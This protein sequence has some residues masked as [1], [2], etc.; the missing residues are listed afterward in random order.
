MRKTI[1]VLNTVPITSLLLCKTGY[2]WQIILIFIL[3]SLNL[4]TI[5]PWCAYTMSNIPYVLLGVWVWYLY[6]TSGRVM[7]YADK[8][9]T[10]I[11]SLFPYFHKT[12]C[13]KCYQMM[14]IKYKTLRYH[15]YDHDNFVV[16]V[17]YNTHSYWWHVIAMQIVRSW[18][19]GKMGAG[20]PH[21]MSNLPGFSY[22]IF[23]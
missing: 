1:V 15:Q 17:K 3:E 5:G 22:P 18:N 23:C 14:Y 6:Q 11:W 19:L 9:T 4:C 10:K 13:W 2:W 7:D 16:G 21:T 20:W 12:C 8:G